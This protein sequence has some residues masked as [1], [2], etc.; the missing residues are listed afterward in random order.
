M[1]TGEAA[2]RWVGYRCRCTLMIESRCFVGFECY[3]ERER[4]L[5]TGLEST[6]EYR[7][8]VYINQDTYIHTRGVNYHGDCRCLHCHYPSTNLVLPRPS[9]VLSHPTHARRPSPISPDHLEPSTPVCTHRITLAIDR[10][11]PEHERALRR[12]MAGRKTSREAGRRLT[13]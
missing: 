12:G 9:L 10:K 4:V 2:C 1:S 11:R 3:V 7:R 6:T 5:N 13:R 8:I